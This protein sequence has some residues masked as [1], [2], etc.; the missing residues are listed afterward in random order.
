MKITLLHPPL[1]DPTLPYHSTAYLRGHLARNGF[2]DVSTR[3]LNIEFVNYCLEGPVSQ[4]LYAAAEQRLGSLRSKSSLTFDEQEQYYALWSAAVARPESVQRAVAALR[5]RQ[6]FLDHE[7]YLA[8]VKALEGFFATL[9][10]LSYPAE[11]INFKLKGHG[12]YSIYNLDDL[13][14]PDLCHRICLPL[15]S[16]FYDRCVADPDLVASDC[17]GISI[18]Y[19]HQLLMALH[20]ARLIKQW[21]RGKNVLLGGTSISQTYKYLR[22]KSLLKRFFDVCDGIVVG[23]GETAICEIADSNGDL[24]GNARIP[25][26]ITYDRNVDKLHLPGAIHYENVAALGRPVYEYPWGLYMAPE[27]AIN[28][29]PTRGCYWYLFTFCDYGLNTD[30]PTSPWRERPGPVVIVDL[31]QIQEQQGVRY[32]YFAVDV[33]APRYLEKLSDALVDAKL[34]LRWSAE[35]RM[36]KIFSAQRVRLDLLRYGI[37]KPTS[38]RSHR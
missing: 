14:N 32:V 5:D 6:T 34:D 22:D 37:W 24:T 20:L 28:D 19:D 21:W 8:S 30:K 2:S 10:A 33:M 15:E 4:S 38:P 13:F 27:R 7:T 26:L 23:E 31:Q 3:D 25:N 9:S 16:F 29:A 18:V 12:R 1:D 11:I 35:L 36:E 17:I